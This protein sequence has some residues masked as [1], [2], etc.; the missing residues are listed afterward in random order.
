M[1]QGKAPEC[2]AEQAAL[3]EERFRDGYSIGRGDAHR[4]PE[5]LCEL[6]TLPDGTDMYAYRMTADQRLAADMLGTYLQRAGSRG[7]VSGWS[8]LWVR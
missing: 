2:T 1:S 8:S 7:P 5:P 3:W 6:F 4:G